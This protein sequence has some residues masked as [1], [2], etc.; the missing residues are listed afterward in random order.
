MRASLVTT[1]IIAG[2]LLAIAALTSCGTGTAIVF[3]KEGIQIVP[4]EDIIII[5][6]T[7]PRDF[8]S[9]K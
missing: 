1:I 7:D 4:P 6:G 5:P 3:G 2:A 9:T 8:Q